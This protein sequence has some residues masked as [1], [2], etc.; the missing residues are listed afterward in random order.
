MSDDRG[1]T[2]TTDLRPVRRAPGTRLHLLLQVPP[3]QFGR[4]G[5]ALAAV[6]GVSPTTGAPPPVL[7]DDELLNRVLARLRDLP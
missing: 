7:T 2:A 5:L 6:V 4:R 3:P 1:D